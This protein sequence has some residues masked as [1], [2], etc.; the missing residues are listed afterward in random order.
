MKL[1]NLVVCAVVC[2][3]AVPSFAATVNP[4]KWEVKVE[5]EMTGMP[6]K[7]PPQ[8]MTHCITKEDAEKAESMVKGS[9]P[10]K[11]CKITDIATSG[12]TVTWKVECPTQ[13]LKGEG[14]MTYSAETYTGST[15][16]KMGDMEMSQ[17]VSGKRL[18]A[19]DEK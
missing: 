4:G 11:D 7:I 19:C 5:T 10:S 15:K 9:K 17:K 16:F 14:T 2:L 13:N 6:A 18:G 3:L 12:N 8:T 1:R